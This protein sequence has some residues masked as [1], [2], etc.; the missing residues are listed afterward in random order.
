M[1]EQKT[2]RYAAP[3]ARETLNDPH[4]FAVL[5]DMLMRGA[6][7]E[8]DK[9]CEGRSYTVDRVRMSIRDNGPSFIRNLF[10]AELE[11]LITPI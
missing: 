11:I 10:D 4:L 9:A 2:I 8:A 5:T 7:I 6:R 1:F 3:V